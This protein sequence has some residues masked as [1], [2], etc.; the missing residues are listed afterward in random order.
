LSGTGVESST[1][2]GMRSTQVTG[3]EQLEPITRAPTALIIARRIRDA[4]L[5]GALSPGTRMVETRLAEQLGVSR[6]PI[7][8]ALQRL[9]QE[10]LME[11][12]RRGVYIRELTNEDVVDVYFARTACGTAA[13]EAIMQ[14]PHRV[15]WEVL[16][17]ALSSL[18]RAARS[19]DLR[20]TLEADRYFHEKL[21]EAAD[22]PRLSRMF[23]TLLV[24]TAVCIRRLE[25]AYDGGSHLADEHRRILVALRSGDRAEVA[26]AITAHMDDAIE[27]LTGVPTMGVE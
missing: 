17:S 22:S 24:E 27:H 4:M 19:S 14:A 7:R 8:E 5:A 23:G 10:G 20:S 26:L 9:I 12:R 21:V 11:N 13:A 15:Q 18:E 25:G 3:L 2:L 1:R 6:A 16:E